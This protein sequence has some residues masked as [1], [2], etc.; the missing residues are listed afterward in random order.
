[1]TAGGGCP[2]Q[3]TSERRCNTRYLL[4][5]VTRDNRGTMNRAT[6]IRTA[7]LAVAA[8]TLLAEAAVSHQPLLEYS[9][10]EAGSGSDE[11]ITQP[12]LDQRLPL[13]C[14]VWETACAENLSS[15]RD[16][17]PGLDTTSCSNQCTRGRRTCSPFSTPIFDAERRPNRS[18]SPQRRGRTDQRTYGNARARKSFTRDKQRTNCD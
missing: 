8:L 7:G 12:R 10:C 11:T 1:M 9:T 15:I 17:T 2:N 14:S 4:A 16:G 18:L 6:V 3:S 5:S 13:R